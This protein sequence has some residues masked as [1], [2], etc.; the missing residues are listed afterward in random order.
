MSSDSPRSLRTL[1]VHG[2][3]PR[4]YPYDAVTAP[5]AQ[6]AAYSLANTAELIAYFGGLKE[7]EEDG[8]YGDPTVR[9]VEEKIAALE[10]AEDAVAFSTGMAAVTTAI[11]SLVKSGSHVIL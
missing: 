3:E 4:T 9:L 8:R 7:R 6:T 2:G 11:L 5:I 10:G 1:A